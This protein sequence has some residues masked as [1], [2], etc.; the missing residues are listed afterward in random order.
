MD[1][2][3]GQ[4]FG[5]VMGL[6]MGGAIF[7]YRSLVEEH[8]TLGLSA[9]LFMV[10]ADVRR[11]LGLATAHETRELALY[12]ADLVQRLAA[13]GAKLAT[14][15]A[16]A[17]QICA[18]E[19]AVLSPLPLV[20]LVDVIADEVERRKLRRIS[21]FGARVT[22]ESKMFGRLEDRA[23]VISPRKDE[24][25]LLN[26]MY[27]RIV[28][29]EHATQ[30]EYEALRQLAHELVER[31]RLDA[32][33]LAGTDLSFVFRPDNTDFPHLDGARVHVEAIM[34]RIAPS[35]SL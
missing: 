35:Q 24:I 17:P 4:K 3:D 32:I 6:G 7:Y 8:R 9:H 21:I 10:H 20:G 22:V 13:G 27:A 29:K 34:R 11:V 5:L 25:D 12:L 19:L 15:P 14:V 28:E 33:V 31:E 30:E 2:L 26:E 16:F 23:E 1:E 18:E